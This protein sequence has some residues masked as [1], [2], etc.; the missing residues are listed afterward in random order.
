MGTLGLNIAHKFNKIYGIEINGDA[1]KSALINKKI[2]MASNVV[3]MLGDAKEVLPKIKDKIS[4]AIVDP[5]RSG[6]DSK[7]LETLIKLDLEQLV[8]ISCDAVT[9]ARDLK[10]LQNKYELKEIKLFD[11]FPGTYHVETVVTLKGGKNA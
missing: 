11:V 1:I 6:L 7:V 2:N 9:L 5:P 4:T 3:Y 8:Y 10:L